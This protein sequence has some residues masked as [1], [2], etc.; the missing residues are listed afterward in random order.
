M[1]AAASR[2]TGHEVLIEAKRVL[3]VLAVDEGRYQRAARVAGNRPT[4]RS[5]GGYQPHAVRPVT[6]GPGE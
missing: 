5:T 2:A 4:D 6:A 3:N 1:G